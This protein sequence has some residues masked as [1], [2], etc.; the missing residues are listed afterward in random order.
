MGGALIYKVNNVSQGTLQGSY[1]LQGT[2]L[3][4][5]D[6]IMAGITKISETISG[7]KI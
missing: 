4:Q 2:K 1:Q 3:S 7:S 6:T 5:E